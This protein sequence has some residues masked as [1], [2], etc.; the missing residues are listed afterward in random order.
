MFKWERAGK[1]QW[2]VATRAGTKY[3]H[4]GMLFDGTESGTKKKAAA[5]SAWTRWNTNAA[6]MRV[7]T[8]WLMLRQG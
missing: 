7:R 5:A 6:A 8:V 2:V 1:W 4:V 3:Q